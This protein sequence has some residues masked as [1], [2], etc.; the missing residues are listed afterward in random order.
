MRSVWPGDD[1]ALDG[2]PAGA[3]CTRS[4]ESA[5]LSMPVDCPGLVVRRAV[6]PRTCCATS[7]RID[8]H[9]AGAVDRAAVMFRSSTPRGAPPGSESA[10]RPP[11]RATGEHLGVNGHPC[12]VNP[13]VPG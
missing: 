9:R 11:P 10:T 13:V 6:S 8:E 2:G 7:G 5:D 12:P 1:Y 3:T 4:D